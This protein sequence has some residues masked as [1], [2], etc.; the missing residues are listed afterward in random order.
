MSYLIVMPARNEAE[1]IADCL[2]CLVMQ[3]RRP[4]LV[5]V[6]DDGSS[7]GTGDI[8]ESFAA[9]HAWIRVVRKP[10]RGVRSVGPGV[11][12]TFY[13]GLAQVQLSDFSYVCKLD[14]DMTFG[15]EYFDHAITLLERDAKLASVSGKVFNPKLRPG[16]LIEERI[17]DEHTAGQAKLYKLEAFTEIGGFVRQVMWDGIDCHMA[18]LRGWKVMSVDDPKLRLYH[19]RLM[20]S[21][22]KSVFHGRLRWGR[23]QYFMG[24]HPLYVVAS[25]INRML[26]R[27]YVLGGILIVA[28]YCVSAIRRVPR[29]DDMVFRSYLRKWQLARLF[30]FSW[31]R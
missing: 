18:R 5:I 29:F 12:E 30:S 20:G 7:D 13:F 2:N 27:P 10:D 1:F 22:Y 9:E 23:G 3:T 25:G 26:E 19:H 31:M 11:I 8:V 21:S 6:V 17:I 15:N 24:S 14:A 28:G 4:G 16:K